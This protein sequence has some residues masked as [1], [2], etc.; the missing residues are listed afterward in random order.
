MLATL[1]IVPRLQIFITSY[2][3]LS[4]FIKTD[5]LDWKK[6]YVGIFTISSQA[7]FLSHL[8]TPCHSLSSRLKKKKFY[9]GNFKTSSQVA[10]FLSH[11]IMP[12][13]SLSQPCSLGWKENQLMLATLKLVR[14]LQIF[15]HMLSCLVTP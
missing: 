8:I 10:D 6:N 7:D 9:L 13:H 5:P 1:Q 15:Y 11:L 4:L 14:R 3:T 2:H 12:C